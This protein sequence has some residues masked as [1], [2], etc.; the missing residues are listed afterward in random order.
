MGSHAATYT[1]RLS[2]EVL[3]RVGS[4]RHFDAGRAGEVDGAVRYYF[5]KK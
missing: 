2:G 4:A 5:T 3:T 1:L